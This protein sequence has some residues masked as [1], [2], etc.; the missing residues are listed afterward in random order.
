MIIGKCKVLSYDK[1]KLLLKYNRMPTH[2][3]MYLIIAHFVLFFCDYFVKNRLFYKLLEML[4]I[5]DP[6]MMI[7]SLTS[8]LLKTMP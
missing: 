6:L 8:K 2:R 5:S 7:H 4:F 3:N 1:I